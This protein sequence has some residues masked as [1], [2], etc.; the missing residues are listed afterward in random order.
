MVGDLKIGSLRLSAPVLSAPIAGFTD[1]IFRAIVRDFGGCGLIYTEMVSASGW[2]DGKFP[3]DRLQ[4]VA[5]EPRPLGVQL[6]YRVNQPTRR[7]TPVD[8]RNPRKHH[9]YPIQSVLPRM[10]GR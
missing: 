8:H 1:R 4:G 10:T 5:D 7:L 9:R 3:P 2:I 6:P